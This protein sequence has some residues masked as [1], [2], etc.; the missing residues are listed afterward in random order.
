M[1]DISQVKLGAVVKHDGA[2]FAI[3]A[4]NQKQM[5]RGG[6]IKNLKLKNLITGAVQEKTMQGNEKMEEADIDRTKAT[7]LYKE[8]AEA[9]FMDAATYEQFSI[10]T[11]NLGHAI[12]FLK[13]GTEVTV[14][15]FE[16][17]PV[18]VQIPVKIELK[19][20]DAPPGVKGDSVGTATKQITLETGHIVN[21]PL[22]IKQDDVVRI[23]T[24]TGEYV[25]RV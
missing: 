11:E 5:G 19:V 16:G 2:P 14:L 21:A 25:E 4:A 18:S 15:N 9:H 6:S 13:D 3:V 10:S 17:K 7:Y 24:E 8:G 23:N 12:N 20:K 22:F 1:F